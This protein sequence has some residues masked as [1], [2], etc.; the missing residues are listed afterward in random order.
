MARHLAGCSSLLTYGNNYGISCSLCTILPAMRV[1]QPIHVLQHFAKYTCL[2]I[3]RANSLKT[4]AAVL[5]SVCICS[6]LDAACSVTLMSC[7]K[8]VLGSRLPCATR[9]KPTLASH[10]CYHGISIILT[11]GRCATC[12]GWPRCCSPICLCCSASCHAVSD[13]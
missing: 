13:T 4:S 8:L 7:R 3:M 12:C 10:S 11:T 1:S 5:G 2:C 9:R 6:A